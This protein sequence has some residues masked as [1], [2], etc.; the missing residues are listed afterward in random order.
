MAKTIKFNLI[1]DNKPVRTIEDLQENFS[2]ED[3]LK[4]YNNG[5]LKKWLAVRG[6]IAELEKVEAMEETD[7]LKIIKELI[8]IFNVEAD[9]EKVEQGVYMLNFRKEEE[10]LL[11]I[12]NE[13]KENRDTI[14]ADYRTGYDQ[15]KANIIEHPNDIAEIKACIWEMTTNYEWAFEMDHRKLFYELLD[16]SPLAI[17]CLLMNPY[18]RKYYLPIE[19]DTAE[20]ESLQD[21]TG[22]VEQTSQKEA[23]R[24]DTAPGVL[25]MTTGNAFL[26][27]G[28]VFKNNAALVGE[29]RWDIDDDIDKRNM[30]KKICDMCKTS[31]LKKELGSYVKTFHGITDGYWKDLEPKGRYYMI[32]SMEAGDFVR[33]AGLTGGD[34]SQTDVKNN[35]LIVDGIDYKSNSES[36]ELLYMEV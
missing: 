11:S 2:I 25:K 15:L 31:V 14:I 33:S 21:D 17:M 7:A 24:E 27:M 29:S 9:P 23:E 8:L 36:H 22:T 3:V 5:L 35:F 20:N 30:Y 34:L 18:S 6:Y 1:C 26:L 28:E 12:Y 4:Y 13:R 19:I 16:V 32:L 10:E